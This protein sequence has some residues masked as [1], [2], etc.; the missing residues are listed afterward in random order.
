MKNWIVRLASMLL[1]GLVFSGSG[2]AQEW[3]NGH[4]RLICPFPAGAAVDLSARIMAE[5]L[6]KRLGVPVV[7]ENRGGGGGTIG[8]ESVARANPDGNTLGWPAGD[9]I[10]IL[11]A[12]K[13]VTPYRVPDDF[14]FVAKFVDTALLIAV[15]KDLPVKNVQELI[16]YAKANPE[17]LRSGTS[18]VASAADVVTH[19][20]AKASGTKVVH[21]HYRGLALAIGD[22]LG[23]HIDMIMA[24]PS[25]VMPLE[26]SG[27][28]RILA[29]TSET[30]LPFLPDVPTVKEAGLQGMEFSNWYGMLAPQ[31]TPEKILERLRK[32][33]AAIAEDSDVR[34]RF[35]KANLDVATSYAKDFEQQVVRDLN[36]L[37]ALSASEN[38]VLD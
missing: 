13:K 19:L 32:E 6:S 8:M 1:A 11:P 14:A 10:S 5:E 25:T 33:I 2:M 24:T 15:R 27:N 21:V 4:I 37:K 28:V 38:I 9:A 34:A 3:P 31:K 22:L 30:R 35:A 20:F 36:K 23:G 26:K 29:A 16:T 17:Q 7:V 18:G 12:F